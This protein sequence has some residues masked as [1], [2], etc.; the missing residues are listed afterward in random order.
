MDWDDIHERAAADVFHDMCADKEAE[1][2]RP[3]TQPEENEIERLA[4][5][6]DTSDR[7]QEL[8]EDM[9][10]AAYDRAKYGGEG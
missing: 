5:N 8:Y 4:A 9:A 2:G 6:V 7:V 1:L 10:S 3:L